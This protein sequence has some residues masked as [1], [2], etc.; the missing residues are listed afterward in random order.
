[1]IRLVAALVCSIEGSVCFPVLS[2]HLIISSAL[3]M[4]PT[5]FQVPFF[6]PPCSN[7]ALSALSTEPLSLLS[8]RTTYSLL[9]HPLS[10]RNHCPLTLPIHRYKIIL[11]PPPPIVVALRPI[12]KN[13]RFLRLT[14]RIASKSPGIPIRDLL[15][16][17]LRPSSLA[18]LQTSPLHFQIEQ[19]TPREVPHHLVP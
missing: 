15:Y 1:M 13:Q 18:P 4:T 14:L 19:S 2:S 8:I 11:I 3:G 7:V 17:K 5:P 9:I 12:P 16:P 10:E 6:L